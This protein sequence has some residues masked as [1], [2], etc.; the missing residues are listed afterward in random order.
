MSAPKRDKFAALA[1]AQQGAR[2]PTVTDPDTRQQPSA[3]TS[4]DS[5]AMQ[6]SA[7]ATTNNVEGNRRAASSGAGRGGKFAALQ[8][9][10][11]TKRDDKFSAMASRTASSLAAASSA[12]AAVASKQSNEKLQQW[13]SKCEQR[14]KLW[15]ELEEA[16]L[17]VLDIL[18]YA[19]QTVACFARQTTTDTIDPSEIQHLSSQVQQCIRQLHDKLS[20]AAQF[21]QAYRAPERINKLYQV[22]VEEGL[23][24]QKENVLKEL[25]ELEKLDRD[26][27]TRKRRRQE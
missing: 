16:E 12:A 8:K 26:E 11:S 18:D 17:D 22:R 7:S 10:S 24:V 21:I 5:S 6:A 3:S 25:V 4:S 2:P 1:A 20:P 13:N 19:Q 23:A 15:R 9:S 14:E 27:A